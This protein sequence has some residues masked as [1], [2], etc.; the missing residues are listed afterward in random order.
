LVDI[1]KTLMKRAGS[2]SVS[3]W[4]GSADLNP[5]QN[6]TDRKHRMKSIGRFSSAPPFCQ[7]ALGSLPEKKSKR[8]ERKVEILTEF[9]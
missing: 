2:G 1:L 5:Y 4:Y 3:D 7:L 8:E 6:V 9:S